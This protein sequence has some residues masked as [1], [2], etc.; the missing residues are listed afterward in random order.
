[1]STARKGAPSAGVLSLA[2][3]EYR[4]VAVSAEP[5]AEHTSFGVGGPADAFFEPADLA[6]L[7]I[8]L[9]SLHDRSAHVTVIGAG[10]NLLVSDAG[11]RGAVVRIGEDFSEIRIDG[12]KVVCGAGALLRAVSA[13]CAQADLSGLEFASGIPGT[14]GGAV[15]M[16]AGAWGGEISDVLESVA[17]VS[18]EGRL[19]R[20]KASDLGLGYRL[21][22]LSDSGS[23]VVEAAFSLEPADPADVRSRMEELDRKRSSRQPAG[24]TA[25]CAFKNPPGNY[26]SRLLEEA[27]AKGL[28]VGGARVSERHA[29]FVMN[30]GGATAAEIRELIEKMRS[31]VEAKFCLRLETEI[32]FV[33][34]W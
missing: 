32:E 11:V 1:M 19:R 23:I 13:R 15:V 16:N 9:R 17:L 4:G 12:T 34:E 28:S 20:L 27:G 14:V 25:G 31:A 5:L 10:T 7:V 29:N 3:Q 30:S 6:D 26:A 21:S 8:L 33:G 24:R 22:A 18:R 2:P